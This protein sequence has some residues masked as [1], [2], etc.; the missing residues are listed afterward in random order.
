MIF[1]KTSGLALKHAINNGTSA[2]LWWLANNSVLV[3]SSWHGVKS[4]PD[5]TTMVWKKKTFKKTNTINKH[6][7]FVEQWKWYD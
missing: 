4:S 3:P 1:G 7:L 2:V 6:Q 5:S